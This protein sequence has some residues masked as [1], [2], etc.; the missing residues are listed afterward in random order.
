MLAGIAESE[1]L[2]TMWR[3]PVDTSARSDTTR[4]RR[5]TYTPGRSGLERHATRD[6]Q[7]REPCE[8]CTGGAG[9]QEGTIRPGRDN[10]TNGDETKAV[11]QSRMAFF[12]RPDPGVV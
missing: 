8:H 4:H 12:W 6:G 5:K 7:R 3:R 2:S 11:R 10:G 9:A 1:E